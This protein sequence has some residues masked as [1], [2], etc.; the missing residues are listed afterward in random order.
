MEWFYWF[1]FSR[2]KRTVAPTR[3]DWHTKPFQMGP[4]L[5]ASLFLVVVTGHLNVLEKAAEKTGV[6]L[7]ADQ[8]AALFR[9]LCLFYYTL[10]HTLLLPTRIVQTGRV[11]REHMAEFRTRVRGEIV[12]AIAQAGY[13]PETYRN[14][15]TD[16][17]SEAL[18][19][20]CHVYMKGV[21]PASGDGDFKKILLVGPAALDRF[22]LE[23]SAQLHL[24]T[25]Q[26]VGLLEFGDALVHQAWW[27]RQSRLP[28]EC[29]LLFNHIVPL[30]E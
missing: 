6:R 13:L 10:W 12:K 30:P 14:W 3:A 20:H 26:I 28:A 7:S 2:V 21:V 23:L 22:V 1:K 8:K 5:L 18:E 19:T 17:S 4:S 11:P 16:S 24:Q 9:Q 27:S 25:C 15:A 29:V